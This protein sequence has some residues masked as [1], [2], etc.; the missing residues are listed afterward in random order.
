MFKSEGR[1]VV[2]RREDGQSHIDPIKKR[3]LTGLLLSTRI[4]EA[5]V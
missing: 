2:D 4:G 3:E 1:G 5:N